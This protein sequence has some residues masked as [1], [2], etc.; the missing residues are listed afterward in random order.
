MLKFSRRRRDEKNECAVCKNYLSDEFLLPIVQIFTRYRAS[1][2]HLGIR[3]VKERPQGIFESATRGGCARSAFV[4]RQVFKDLLA[5]KTA[6]DVR[7]KLRGADAFVAQHG[8][9][10]TQVGSPFEQMRGKGVAQR[11]RRNTLRDAR[12]FGIYLQVV[13]HRDA[14]KM[15]AAPVAH[16]HVVLLARADVDVAA[17]GKPPL[18]LP[19]R[20]GRN[21]YQALLIALSRHAHKALFKVQVAHFQ[22]AK[23]AHAQPATVK[24]LYNRLIAL[25]LGLRKVDGRLKAFHLVEREHLRKVVGPFGRFEQFGRVGVDVAVLQQKLEVRAHP[26]QDARNGGD[27]YAQVVERSGKA[28]QVVEF[29]GAHVEPLVAEVLHEFG[30]V[31]HIRRASVGRKSFFQQQ[32][33]AVFVDGLHVDKCGWFVARRYEKRVVYK[34]ICAVISVPLALDSDGWHKTFNRLKRY[35]LL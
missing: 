8:L 16:E 33:A 20:L 11:V 4:A 26:R 12:P 21:G 17:V 28:V 1:L 19:H 22:K 30:H 34:K 14:R 9:N 32:V 27:G 10:G 18:Q 35:V 7:V 6:V 5:Q 31:L 24:H 13:K 3:F 15:L 29:H 25:P 2:R 23:L